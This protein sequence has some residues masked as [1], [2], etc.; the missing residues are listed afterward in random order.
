MRGTV[1]GGIV[2]MFVV[3]DIGT[4]K[5]ILGTVVVMGGR[6]AAVSGRQVVKPGVFKTV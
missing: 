5:V 3:G 4:A 6:T 1:I 2:A